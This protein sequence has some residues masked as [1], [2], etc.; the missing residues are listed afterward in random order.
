MKVLSILQN[1]HHRGILLLLM[2]TLVWGTSFPLNKYVVNYLS[3]AV[4]L[5]V[6]FTISAIALAPWLRKLNPR[7]LRDGGLLGSLYCAECTLALIALETTSASRAAF[8]I[9]LNAILVPLSGALLGRN[10]P[11][12]ILLAAAMAVLGIG[13]M[14]WEGGGVNLGDLLTLICAFGATVYVL[15]LEVVTPRHP[16]LPLVATQLTVMTLISWVWAMPQLIVQF[17]AIASHFSVILYLGLG[18]TVAPIWTQAIAQRSIASYEAALIY[19]LEPVF[20]TLFSFWFLGETLGMRGAVGAVLVLSATVLSQNTP[21][22]LLQLRQIFR[23]RLHSSSEN[24]VDA[25]SNSPMHPET[26]D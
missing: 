3:P 19:T 22:G 16:T 26:P 10:M 11:L 15:L 4:I 25:A 5:T 2:T 20:A 7:L 18:V 8:I 24:S 1:P 9:S 23:A 6:R 21:K 17:N 14:S 12:R 13:V